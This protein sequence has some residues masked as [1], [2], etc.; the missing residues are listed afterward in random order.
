MYLLVGG[1]GLLGGRVAVRMREAGL[2]V[3]ALVRPTTSASAIAALGAE[4]CWGDLRDP[5]SLDHAMRDVETVV[6]TANAVTRSLAGDQTLTIH[7][8]DDIGNRNLVGAAERARVR[9]FVF[10][11]TERDE[12]EVDTPFTNAKLATERRLADSRLQPVIVR[13]D[14]FQEVWL[15]PVVGVDLPN[16][17]VRVFGRGRTHRPYVAVD[18]VAAAIVRLATM[19][20]PPREAVLAGPDSV[21]IDDIVEIWRTLTGRDVSVRHVP[22]PALAVGTRVLR[23]F[24]PTLASVMGMALHADSVESAASPATLRDLGIEPRPVR[25]Y[26]ADLAADL[27]VPA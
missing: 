6:T 10:V 14:A 23:P 7:D 3:R 24:R 27:L 19:D 20:D 17:H 2:P 13:P 4:V 1:T 25:A 16:G 11:S 21:S 26:L 5:V 22:R 8:V 18:D 15:S 9:R 12:L